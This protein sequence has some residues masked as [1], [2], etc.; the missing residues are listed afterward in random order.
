MS[1]KEIGCTIMTLR[2]TS[3]CRRIQEQ[4]LRHFSHVMRM[5]DSRYLETALLRGVHGIRQSR[6]HIKC[7]IDSIKEDCGTLGMTITQASRTAQDRNNWRTIINGL[8]M[9]V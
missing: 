6:R 8:P 5:N 4:D 1:H 3:I 2:N 9:H 7:W